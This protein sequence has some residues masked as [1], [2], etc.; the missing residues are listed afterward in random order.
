MN[1]PLVDG[2]EYDTHLP[3]IHQSIGIKE[4]CRVKMNA[5]N[6]IGLILVCNRSKQRIYQ[7][8]FN[9]FV[10]S[11][12]NPRKNSRHNGNSGGI[13]VLLDHTAIG[14]LGFVWIRLSN[15]STYK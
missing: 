2:D 1:T 9:K 12:S 7:T 5:V 10:E 3:P 15:R 14:Q 6:E 4:K 8:T 11:T 13:D